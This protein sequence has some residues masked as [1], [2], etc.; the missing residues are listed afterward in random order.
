MTK[1]FRI[2]GLGFLIFTSL[3]LSCKKEEV[4]VVTTTTVSNITAT[5]ATSGGNITDE[6]SSTVIS[7]GVCWSTGTSPTISDSK[8]TDG[9]GLGSFSSNLTGLSDG[10]TYYVTAYATNN[11]GTGY[12]NKISFTTDN[13]L[14]DKYT[15]E[16]DNTFKIYKV[17]LSSWEYRA[18]FIIEY[19]YS[20]GSIQK[21][22]TYSGQPGEGVSTYYINDSGLADSSH[23]FFYYNNE[24]TTSE[25]SY[26]FY[27]SNNYL[28]MKID[29]RTDYANQTPD[30]TFYDY[31]NGNCMKI[32]YPPIKIAFDISFRAYTY[33]SIKNLIDI[34]S[35]D[36][37][38]IGK[39][40]QNLIE[41]ITSDGVTSHED[42]QYIMNSDGLVKER[43]KTMYYD[44]I[45]EKR[46]DKF[47]YKIR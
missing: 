4:P 28:K 13:V 6:G 43:A 16:I 34:E 25:T 12:G 8:T 33:N 39:L 15:L 29:K 35:F 18:N 7:R 30:T 31:K 14:I 1:T 44:Q 45:Q 11:I 27:D 17:S 23:F 3:F 9:S 42:Y 10:T 46:I 38:F 40:N 5:T 36:E 20:S 37:E 19:I 21:T 24:V 32:T 2:I 41:S 47:E 26:F 22:E